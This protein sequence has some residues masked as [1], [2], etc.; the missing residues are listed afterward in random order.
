MEIVDEP[1]R[2]LV[3]LNKSNVIVISA[4]ANDIYK[5]NSKVAL[6]KTIKFIQN[7]SLTNIIL[8]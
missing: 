4:G 3:S 6:V 8:L 2:D 5:N 7:N 1:T